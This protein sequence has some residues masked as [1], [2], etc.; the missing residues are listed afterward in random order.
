MSVYK[1]PAFSVYG[2]IERSTDLEWLRAAAIRY[3][4]VMCE[5]HAAT[6]HALHL[7]G[8]CGP[9]EAGLDALDPELA[10]DTHKAW[11]ANYENALYNPVGTV[12]R[13]PPPVNWRPTRFLADGGVS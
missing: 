6:G 10:C 13:E 11:Q 4:Q 5:Q 3:H 1:H 7:D 12:H 8:L 9:C 2:Q